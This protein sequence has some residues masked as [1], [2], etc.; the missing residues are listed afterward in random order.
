MNNGAKTVRPVCVIAGMPR[1]STTFLYYTLAKHPSC[2]VPSRKELEFFSINEARGQEWYYDFYSAMSDGQVGFDISPLYFFSPDLPEKIKAFFKTPRVILILRD[3]VDF[4]IS[5][6]KN[7]VGVH[8]HE[9]GFEDFISGYSYEKD[10]SSIELSIRPGVIRQQIDSYRERLG[11]DILLVDFRAMQAVPLDV[12][13][14][15]EKFCRIP[16]YFSAE[17]FENVRVNASDQVS[18]QAINKLMHKKWFAD[19]VTTLVPKKLIMAIRYRLQA[20]KRTGRL[21]VSEEDEE[22]YRSLVRRDLAGDAE[23][24]AE[25]FVDSPFVLGTGKTFCSKIPTIGSPK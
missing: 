25:I 15:I 1:A 11:D 20:S 10:G 18:V 3:P 16:P 13:T 12:L 24:M 6:Y 23:F 22:Q 7:R 2:F 14:A 21:P 19:L 17:N 9:L 5:F 8:G 4:A